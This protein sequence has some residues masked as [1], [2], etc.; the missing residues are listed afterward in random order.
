MARS[1]G[2]SR[3]TR[4][5]DRLIEFLNEQADEHRAKIMVSA[6]R[7]EHV[8]SAVSRMIEDE[9]SAKTIHN[10]VTLLRAMLAGKKGPSAIRRGLAFKDP[11][12]GLELPPL[13][14]RQ[15]TP[16]NPEP[17][18]AL[19]RAAKALAGSATP[20]RNVSRI[21]RPASKRSPCFAVLRY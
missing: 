3:R 13:E 11:T 1:S 18:W 12:L 19:I 2:R 7:F 8:D 4:V 14:S 20:L 5:P 10:A 21:H 15:I 17:V 16:P 9:L 6:L